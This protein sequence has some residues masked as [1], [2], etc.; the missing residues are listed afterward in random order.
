MEGGG[1]DSVTQK[2]SYT[3]SL[4]RLTLSFSDKQNWYND[5]WY[6]VAITYDPTLAKSNLVFY[7]NGTVD[8]YYNSTAAVVY[9]TPTLQIG[10]QAGN[11]IFY[12]GLLDEV[13]LWNVSRTQTEI[14][15][16]W[17]WTLTDPNETATAYPTLVGYWHFDNVTRGNY[18][19]YSICHNDA[20]PT[21]PP[22]LVAPGAPIITIPEFSSVIII[23][24]V[25]TIGTLCALILP[26]RPKKQGFS[27][28]S[29]KSA[30]NAKSRK[31]E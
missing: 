23:T 15:N 24:V 29:K 13:R 14:Q 19:D 17:N 31:L 9:S 6:C 7:V 18:L 12:L 28:R 27:V 22:A 4:I 2:E 30:K 25:M 1:S 21:V 26:R 11:S 5:S 10:S 16:T 3:L 20:V 8:S